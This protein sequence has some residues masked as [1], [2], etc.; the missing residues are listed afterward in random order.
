MGWVWADL[1]SEKR[2]GRLFP[3]TLVVIE[4]QDSGT[5]GRMLQRFPISGWGIASGFI[6]GTPYLR[7]Q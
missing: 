5:L 6:R 2:N 4:R 1:T 3:Y 7:I